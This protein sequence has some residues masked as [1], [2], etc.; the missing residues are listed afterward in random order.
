MNYECKY[1]WA[2]NWNQKCNGN[3][4]AWANQNHNKQNQKTLLK[5]ADLKISDFLYSYGNTFAIDIAMK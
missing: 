1:V 2:W 3:Q 4:N 5:I